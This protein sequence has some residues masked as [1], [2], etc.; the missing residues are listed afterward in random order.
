MAKKILNA[1]IYSAACVAILLVFALALN[2]V[3]PAY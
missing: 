1:T 3:Y 2:T